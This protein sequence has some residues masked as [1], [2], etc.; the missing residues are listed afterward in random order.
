MAAS[1]VGLVGGPSDLGPIIA[2]LDE[3][4]LAELERLYDTKR[5]E[6]ILY[7]THV[8]YIRTHVQGTRI[9][10]Y[11]TCGYAYVTCHIRARARYPSPSLSP[12]SDTTAE[13]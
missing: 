2:G 10:L 7:F 12:L 6:G 9:Q 3:E 13:G 1:T 8:P 5:L 11:A 4:P